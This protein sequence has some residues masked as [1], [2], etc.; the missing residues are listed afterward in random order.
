MDGDVIVRVSGVSL[1]QGGP[2]KKKILTDA[3][4]AAG[5]RLRLCIATSSTKRILKERLDAPSIIDTAQRHRVT[6]ECEKLPIEIR[7]S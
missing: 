2:S 3:I 4:K 6:C 7:S 5:D 1:W